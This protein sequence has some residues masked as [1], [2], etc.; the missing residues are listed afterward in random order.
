MTLTEWTHG[1]NWGRLQTRKWN[2]RGCK[3]GSLHPEINDLGVDGIDDGKDEIGNDHCKVIK[4]TYYYLW[5][6]S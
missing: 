5:R 2:R 4:S 6:K 1:N 3:Y